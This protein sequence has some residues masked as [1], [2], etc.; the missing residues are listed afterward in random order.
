[1]KRAVSPIVVVGLAS[2]VGW[3]L[4]KDQIKS[5]FGFDSEGE[6]N[7]SFS[8]AN[9]VEAIQARFSPSDLEQQKVERSGMNVDIIP[10][11]LSDAVR[12]ENYAC[13]MAYD[14]SMRLVNDAPGGPGVSDFKIETKSPYDYELKAEDFNANTLYGQ[15]GVPAA[16]K[17][18][19]QGYSPRATAPCCKPIDS[20]GMD[21]AQL[22][23]V[24]GPAQPTAGRAAL[25]MLQNETSFGIYN[26]E[27]N[28]SYTDG[29]MTQ[30]LAA[31]SAE[32][33]VERINEAEVR[34][35]PHMGGS[36]SMLRRV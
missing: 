33:W 10:Q 32:G 18:M 5:T 23:G 19:D 16:F 12:D 17:V 31:W 20:Y 11:N 3:F 6:E 2:V 30:T 36:E 26:P 25:S 14:K 13:Q 22:E 21:L 9:V 27:V 1:M 34:F 24:L 4:F 8:F 28:D 7:Q 15:E 29:N 35:I